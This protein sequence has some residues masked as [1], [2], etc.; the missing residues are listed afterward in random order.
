MANE[1]AFAYPQ[2]ARTVPV[3]LG[4]PRIP[5]DICRWLGRAQQVSKNPTEEDFAWVVE[6]LDSVVKKKIENLT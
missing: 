2:D 3:V 5:E 1:L 6:M 4:D